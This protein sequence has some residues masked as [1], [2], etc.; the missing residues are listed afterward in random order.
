MKTGPDAKTGDFPPLI[1]ASASPRRRELLEQA[2]YLFTV[3]PANEDVECGVCS[4]S[5][6]AG[7]VTELAYRKAAA[8]RQ[9]LLA[10]GRSISRDGRAIILAADTVADLDGFVLGKPRDESHARA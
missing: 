9:H 7:L 5:G 10:G 4:E 3:V 6:P 8:V 2:G 1:L